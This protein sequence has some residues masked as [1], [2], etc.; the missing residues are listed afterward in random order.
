[1]SLLQSGL[2]HQG[3]AL[4]FNIIPFPDQA[5]NGDGFVF[6]TSPFR[7]YWNRNQT[8]AQS[9]RTPGPMVELRVILLT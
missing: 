4:S 8:V 6:G 9:T 7:L 3:S 2:L 5:D 1:M